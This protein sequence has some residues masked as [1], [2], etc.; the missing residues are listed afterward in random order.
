MFY[1]HV[2]STIRAERF[3]TFAIFSRHTCVTH[4]TISHLFAGG[5]AT[6]LV[7]RMFLETLATSKVSVASLAQDSFFGVRTRRNRLAVAT[8]L[9][10][11]TRHA[12]STPFITASAY[13]R[14]RRRTR[15]TVYDMVMSLHAVIKQV[16][17]FFR[18]HLSVKMSSQFNPP[19]TTILYSLKC[20]WNLISS[21]I[22]P[23]VDKSIPIVSSKRS[24][25][26]RV[27]YQRR[28]EL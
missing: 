8:R 16:N 20:S 23:P 10:A 7:C 25:M 3:E 14:S 12:T 18:F 27:I 2:L 5:L 9:S 19:K 4:G 11:L 28:Y 26:G 24:T 21:G 15:K 6:Q 13:I 22:P 1:F 17:S